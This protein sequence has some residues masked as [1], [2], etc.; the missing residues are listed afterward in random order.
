ML[1]STICLP[2]LLLTCLQII[3]AFLHQFTFQFTFT[4]GCVKC[5]TAGQ[6]ACLIPDRFFLTFCLS[7]GL[8]QLFQNNEQLVLSHT[9]TEKY[10][11]A[12]RGRD[13]QTR[14]TLRQR[15][16]VAL[17][18]PAQ[19]CAAAQG[20]PLSVF[21]CRCILLTAAQ[22]GVITHTG[23]HSARLAHSHTDSAFTIRLRWHLN[24]ELSLFALPRLSPPAE[25]RRLALL[26]LLIFNTNCFIQNAASL[27]LVCLHLN[28]TLAAGSFHQS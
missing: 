3:F 21:V 26:P 22:H 24:N 16:I 25:V 7:K 23:T 15:P 1:C 9:Q 14:Q 19:C 27:S 10:K 20:D 8:I 12:V 2:W 18:L 11:E 4:P 28:V 17:S 5:F 13:R 6:P